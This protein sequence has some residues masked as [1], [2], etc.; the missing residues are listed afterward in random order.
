MIEIFSTF[1]LRSL[2]LVDKM[3]EFAD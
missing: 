2:V 1:E 3:I